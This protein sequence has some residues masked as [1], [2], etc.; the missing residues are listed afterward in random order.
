MENRRRKK[1]APAV[2][3][4]DH[5]ENRCLLR[6]GRGHGVHFFDLALVL[7][8]LVYSLS[9]SPTNSMECRN[10]LEQITGFF[11]ISFSSI[12]FP[13]LL[14]EHFFSSDLMQLLNR[15]QSATRERSRRW[16]PRLRPLA[17]LTRFLIWTMRWCGMIMHSTSRKA[18]PISTDP[19]QAVCIYTF[20][21]CCFF[22]LA[23]G[24]D[25]V[26]QS[27]QSHASST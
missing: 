4:E 16:R 27:P 9:L 10:V 6:R 20:I 7:L 8:S 15:H 22:A 25:E 24:T 23:A 3:D 1:C 17:H 2:A 21:Q 14:L 5:L 19:L 13:I 11:C 12:S 26:S 18:S